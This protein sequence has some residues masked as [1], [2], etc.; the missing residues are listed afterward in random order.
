MKLPV[1][2]PAEALEGGEVIPKLGEMG[3]LSWKASGQ[4][5]GGQ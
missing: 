3:V 1:V 4:Q 2:V 5:L